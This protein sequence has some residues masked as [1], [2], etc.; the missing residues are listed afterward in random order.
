MLRRPKSIETAVK[1]WNKNN[2]CEY[3]EDYGHTT[4]KCHQLKKSIHELVDHGQLNHFLR[5]GG[6]RGHNLRD[7]EGKK[8][9]DADYNTK[10]TA[11]IIRGIDDKE[12]N[13]GYQK[14][15]I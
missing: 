12:L 9:N 2:Y 13:T 5:R 15:Q 14:A 3:H 1:I 11:T 4:S 7:P 10:I 6:G 8:D